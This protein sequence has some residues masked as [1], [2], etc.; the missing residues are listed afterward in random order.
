MPAELRVIYQTES[1]PQ[2]I[3]ATPHFAV[4]GKN[5]RRCYFFVKL[6]WTWRTLGIR[7]SVP[8]VRF[9]AAYS[10]IGGQDFG[11]APSWLSKCLLPSQAF[12][13][14]RAQN[15][16]T[17]TELF[18]TSQANWQQRTKSPMDWPWNRALCRAA[19]CLCLYNSLWSNFPLTGKQQQAAALMIP[20]LLKPQD[21]MCFE[22]IEDKH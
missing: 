5:P 10:Q 7:R 17:G 21:F 3:S 12:Y 2:N 4:H 14:S 22:E 6:W 15:D 16:C 13:R 9:W 11:A 8:Y 18:L 20:S 19:Q 1:S